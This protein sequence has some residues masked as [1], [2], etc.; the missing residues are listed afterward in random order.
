MNDYTSLEHTGNDRNKAKIN[1]LTTQTCCRQSR[2]R[3]LIKIER[4]R[5]DESQRQFIME[6]SNLYEIKR[7]KS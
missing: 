1:N 7:I 2:T 4:I 6:I 3:N 5:A